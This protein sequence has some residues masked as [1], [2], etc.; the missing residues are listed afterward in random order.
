MVQAAAGQTGQSKVT[1][2]ALVWMMIC[3]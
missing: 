1:V 2:V 3:V